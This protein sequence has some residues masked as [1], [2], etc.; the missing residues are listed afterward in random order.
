MRVYFVLSEMWEDRRGTY[1][2]P[3]EPPEDACLCLIVVAETRGRAKYL[4][5][6]SD[7]T[8][9]RYTPADWPLCAVRNIG[10]APGPARVL[11]GHAADAWWGR[12]PDISHPVRRPWTPGWSQRDVAILGGDPGL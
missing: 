9:R 5:I 10:E 12:C 3:P 8:L 1:G 4:A 11:D 7:R 6:K 2:D